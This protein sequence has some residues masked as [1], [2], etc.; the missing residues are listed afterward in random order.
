MKEI[1]ELEKWIK[2]LEFLNDELGDC[3]YRLAEIR[4]MEKEKKKLK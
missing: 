3:E 1:E 2:H 4:E